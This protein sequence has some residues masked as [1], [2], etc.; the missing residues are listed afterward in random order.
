MDA[1]DDMDSNSSDI[2]GVSPV[3]SSADTSSFSYPPADSCPDAN[4]KFR[5]VADRSS[6]P[7]DACRSFTR[8]FNCSIRNS[9]HPRV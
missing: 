4:R 2:F 6:G 8:G 7:T 1:L 9:A 5:M 3:S